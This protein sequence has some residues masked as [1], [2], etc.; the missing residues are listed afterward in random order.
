MAHPAPTLLP[1]SSYRITS[2]P[3]ASSSTSPST[4]SSSSHTNPN[5]AN[6]APYVLNIVSLPTHYAIATSS[7]ANGIRVI[8]KKT[9]GFVQ[10]LGSIPVGDGGST[11]KGGKGRNK[12][13]VHASAG[14]GGESQI[15]AH[16]GGITNLKSFDY[17]L[18]ERKSG[19]LSSGKDGRVV[20]WDDRAIDGG[21]KMYAPSIGSRFRSLLSCDIS[22]D[23]RTIVGGTELQGDDA[24]LVYWDP[25]NPNTPL[26]T[27]TATHSDDITVLSFAP[28]GVSPK[29]PTASSPS[30]SPHPT[31]SGS[32][33]NPLFLLSASSDG[34]LSLSNANEDDE[35]EAM[36]LTGNWGCSIAQAGWVG[37]KGVWAASDMETFSTWS[38]ELEP[39][40]NF[41]IREPGVH[42]E[43]TWVTDYIVTA[44]SRSDSGS[45]AKK[46]PLLSVFVGSNEGDV[47]LISTKNPLPKPKSKKRN[48]AP[49]SSSS[50]ASQQKPAPAPWTLH[51]TWTHGHVG[52]V[53]SLFYDEENGVVVTGGEDSKLRLWKDETVWESQ[54]D[55]GMDVD[56]EDEDEES[57]NEDEDMVVSPGAGQDNETPGHTFNWRKRDLDEDEEEDGEDRGMD[58][59]G[60]KEGK[61]RRQS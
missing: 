12:G 19:L 7:P 1:S 28:P 37:T 59:D 47:S 31:P 52:V 44:R 18:G 21:V 56:G 50:K 34:L 36:L 16:E 51:S 54:S 61:R 25:R 49:S 20:V 32:L 40:L 60:A 26:R 42:G 14:G 35:E 27:H 10:D 6:T 30:S 8:D 15:Q 5:S 11:G 24:I 4:S 33:S 29:L 38:C 43:T 22:P 39:R 3:L 23:G 13:G 55:S 45:Q 17:F 46:K 2:S 41:N 58:V 53:R 57:D 9:L 48:A